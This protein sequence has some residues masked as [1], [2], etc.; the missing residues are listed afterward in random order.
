M[1]KVC[2]LTSVHNAFDSR[3]FRKEAKTLAKMGYAVTL[4]AQ[5]ECDQSVDGI[6]IV[7]L[8][9]VTSRL[10]RIFQG[11][12]LFGKASRLKADVYH[13]H[14]PE[15]LFAGLLLRYFTGGKII[16]DAHEDVPKDIMTKHWIP[17]IFRKPVSVI[18]GLYEIMAASYMSCV[19]AATPA[20]ARRFVRINRV[21][22]INNYPILVDFE[23]REA[24]SDPGITFVYSGSISD[25]AGTLNLIKAIANVRKDL[26]VRL[27]IIGDYI[28]NKFRV[29]VEKALSFAENI[30][31]F[32]RLPQQQL[33]S[34]YRNA[35]A[36]IYPALPVPNNIE[37][38]PNKLFE[39]MMFALP[40]V[41]SDF[42]FWR[43]IIE[44]ENCGLTVDPL[45]IAGI[46]RA[47]E[48]L[49]SHPAE[50]R[51]MGE[52]GRRAVIEKYNWGSED[53]KLTDLYS[54]LL[55]VK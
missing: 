29:E 15:L 20:I 22:V 16:Y 4:I 36:G 43:S 48:Y 21:E 39:F 31:V 8:R 3:I 10:D 37:A 12:Q 19:I 44:G 28:D 13:I 32:N 35:Y 49:A 47:V 45:D 9:P 17:G 7:A 24:S 26:G 25:I 52:N 27:V 55:A 42:T 38:S 41:I 2:I 40:V 5:H 34:I 23:G 54:H 11:W 1:K 51:A 18:F 6:T 14:D 53:K 50:A 46:T 33:F 30:E